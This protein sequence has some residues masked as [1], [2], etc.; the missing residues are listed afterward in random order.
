MV[1]VPK[2]TARLAALQRHLK[3]SKNQCYHLYVEANE[4]SNPDLIQ[5]RD[6]GCFECWIDCP[7]NIKIDWLMMLILTLINELLVEFKYSMLWFIFMVEWHHLI[8]DC[9]AVWNQDL[10]F[11]E[12]RE[13][14]TC[15]IGRLTT[16]PA[17]LVRSCTVAGFIWLLTCGKIFNS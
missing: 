1:I 5:W 3:M 11:S 9:P 16:F 7:S 10:I 2:P 13:M 8:T 4:L 17:L 6:S 15:Q 12:Q 14:Q